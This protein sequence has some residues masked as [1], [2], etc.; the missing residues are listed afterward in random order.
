M[1]TWLESLRQGLSRSP[2]E[3]R[4]AAEEGRG[5]VRRNLQNLRPFVSRH[6]R[7]GLLGALL[8]LLG[9]LLG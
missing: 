2:S 3:D 4:L 1:Q 5:S 6:W 8:I 9:T 7:K